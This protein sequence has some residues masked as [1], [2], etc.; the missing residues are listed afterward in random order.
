MP[1]YSTAPL[2]SLHI[3][4]CRS[5]ALMGS[6]ETEIMFCWSQGKLTPSQ[7]G[8]IPSLPPSNQLFR[9][10]LTAKRELQRSP[11]FKD[12][13]LQPGCRA[14]EF[15][16]IST[17][18]NVLLEVMWTGARACVKDGSAITAPLCAERFRT[19][20]IAFFVRLATSTWVICINI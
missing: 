1:N 17:V 15:E 7:I 10:E 5:Q 18:Q 19:K 14:G 4:L 8:G 20:L 3:G 9:G 13:T 12:K 2:L 11:Y 6:D 16:R